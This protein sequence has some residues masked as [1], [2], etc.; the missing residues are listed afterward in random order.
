[1]PIPSPEPCELTVKQCDHGD[2]SLHIRAATG[3]CLG[4]GHIYYRSTAG[5]GLSLCLDGVWVW[6]NEDPYHATVR[7]ALL[8]A[9]ICMRDNNLDV[10]RVVLDGPSVVGVLV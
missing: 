10:R 4:H 8:A 3:Y 6:H 5:V 7:E 2:I 9:I 1:M